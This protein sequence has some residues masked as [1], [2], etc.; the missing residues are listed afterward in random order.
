LRFR[1][2]ET[3]ELQSEFHE[4]FRAC[5]SID[6]PLSYLSGSIVT[7]LFDEREGMIGGYLTAPGATGRWFSQIPQPTKL[8][9]VVDRTLEL[10][11]VWL[12][13]EMRGRAA[14][15][16]LWTGIGRDLAERDVDYI[17]F[18]VNAQR[19]GLMRLYA[20]MVTELLYEGPV[21]NS[22]FPT[23]RYFYALPERFA[24]LPELYRRD[25][26][27]RRTHEPAVRERV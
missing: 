10:N 4:R 7:G 21:V 14:S 17:V 26:A 20:R 2:L 12:N 19:A 22:S 15:A 27:A 9:A 25:L 1:V 23:G 3:T 8:H 5:S 11:C 24:R 16:E 6:V 18:A 13:V